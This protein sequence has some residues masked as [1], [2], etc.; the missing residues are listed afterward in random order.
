MCH[1][2]IHTHTY[3]YAHSTEHTRELLVGRKY[4]AEWVAWKNLINCAKNVRWGHTYTHA[5]TEKSK[6]VHVRTHALTHTRLHVAYAF[7]K[8]VHRE[9]KA[10]KAQ[11]NQTEIQKAEEE[12]T[13]EETLR[14]WEDKPVVETSERDTKAVVLHTN[15][16]LIQNRYAVMRTMKD[17]VTRKWQTCSHMHI[18]TQPHQHHIHN[19][20]HLTAYIYFTHTYWQQT[21]TD[22]R[23][24]GHFTE[25]YVLC[26][27]S[28][29]DLN[30][31]RASKI[32]L[33]VLKG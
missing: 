21:E 18:R 31:L 17:T 33:L 22:C 16:R 19:T 13:E 32:V 14:V 30:F 26:L 23:S 29:Y 6:C 1:T 3:N 15:K 20:I 12:E 2:H 8:S 25:I 27:L 24:K 28:V 7:R 4:K 10:Q 9:R 11:Q 5:P